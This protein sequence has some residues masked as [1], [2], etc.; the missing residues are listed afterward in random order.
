MRLRVQPVR[1]QYEVLLPGNDHVE[2]SAVANGGVLL[3]DF[4]SDSPGR[5]SLENPLAILWMHA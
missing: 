5:T 2:P 1:M 4:V 3:R